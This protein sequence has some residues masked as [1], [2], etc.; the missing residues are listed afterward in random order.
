MIYRRINR[1]E[2]DI[3]DLMSFL[4]K[5]I[6]EATE[7]LRRFNES[8]E[9]IERIDLNYI[10]SRTMETLNTLNIDYNIMLE[11]FGETLASENVRSILI[12]RNELSTFESFSV[13]LSTEIQDNMQEFLIQYEVLI[14]MFFNL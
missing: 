3:P 1:L 7:N 5:R 8:D 9:F 2:T 11:E 12:D 14:N 4:P 13:I 10:P 6:E